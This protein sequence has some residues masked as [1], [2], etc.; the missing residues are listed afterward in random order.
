[1]SSCPN[2]SKSLTRFLVDLYH[3]FVTFLNHHNMFFTY[4]ITQDRISNAINALI[5]PHTRSA[6]VCGTITQQ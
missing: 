2:G 5:V 3:N 4:Q 6:G 1:M